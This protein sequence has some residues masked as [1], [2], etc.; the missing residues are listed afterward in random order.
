MGYEESWYK[1]WL[2]AAPLLPTR[3]LERLRT[4]LIEDD[5]R[6]L[7]GTT[8]APPPLAC[9]QDWICE[10]ACILG[11]PFAFEDGD[12][13]LI[14]GEDKLLPLPASTKTVGY[15][16]ERFAKVCFEVDQALGEPAAI[17]RLL[18]RWDCDDPNEPSL[19]RERVRQEMIPCVEAELERRKATY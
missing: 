5:P 12:G 3:G 14:G 15:V 18:N 1:V 6:L 8:T 2:T 13:E 11:Y 16:E 9:V 17:R 7:S 19:T 10:G 4:A